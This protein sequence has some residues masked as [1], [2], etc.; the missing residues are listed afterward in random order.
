M[1]QH[2][3]ASPRLDYTDEALTMSSNPCAKKS[4]KR[5]RK[6]KNPEVT[7][8]A[9]AGQKRTKSGKAVNSEDTADSNT[10]DRTHTAIRFS[11]PLVPERTETERKGNIEATPLTTIRQHKQIKQQN[12]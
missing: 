10:D 5:K 7:N 11:S 2:T 9:T 6:S 4:Q 3:D 12:L 8:N 1:R